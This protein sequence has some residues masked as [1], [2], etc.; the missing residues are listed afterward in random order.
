MNARRPPNK[1][2]L[3]KGRRTRPEPPPVP[4]AEPVTHLHRQRDF[5]IGYGNSSGYG[6][7][8]HYVDGHVDPIFRCT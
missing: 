5:G 7:D 6:T 2:P 8:L 4:T 3:P 1:K